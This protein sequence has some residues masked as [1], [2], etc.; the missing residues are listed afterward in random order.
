L[1]GQGAKP[2]AERLPIGEHHS[3]DPADRFAIL[4]GYERYRNLIADLQCSFGPAMIN[5]VGRIASLGNPMHDVAAIV[6]DVELQE[7]VGIGL[8]PFRHSALHGDPFVGIKSGVSMMCPDGNGNDQ[9]CKNPSKA[10][11]ESIFHIP[12]TRNS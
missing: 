8:E 10:C 6:F 4:D 2:A 3:R 7:A 11:H 12:S 5:H 9:N 1:P